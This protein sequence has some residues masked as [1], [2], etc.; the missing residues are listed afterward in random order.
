MGRRLTIVGTWPAGT[1]SGTY[2]V[3]LNDSGTLQ[4]IGKFIV[5][6]NAAGTFAIAES[7]P[8]GKYILGGNGAGPGTITVYSGKWSAGD[9]PEGTWSPGSF[10]PVLTATLKFV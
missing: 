7:V 4:V 8:A 10:D 2:F 1:A 9:R 6:V 3:V 5:P